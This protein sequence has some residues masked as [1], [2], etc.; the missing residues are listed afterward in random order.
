[1]IA[2]VVVT[3]LPFVR[4]DGSL[5]SNLGHSMTLVSSGVSKIVSMKIRLYTRTHKGMLFGGFWGT[6]NLPKSIPLWVLVQPHLVRIMDTF[7]KRLLLSMKGA[8]RRVG[9]AGY[10]ACA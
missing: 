9:V 4:P 3:W 5:S 8:A 2:V 6:K 10:S 1:M 7:H